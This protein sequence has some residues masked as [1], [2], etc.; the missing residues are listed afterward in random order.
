MIR[1]ALKFGASL[2]AEYANRVAGVAPGEIAFFNSLRDSF[3]ALSARFRIDVIHGSKHQVLFSGSPPPW[4][5][6]QAR[7]E[8]ADLMV[9]SFRPVDK[10][11]RLSFIQVKLER[12][13]HSVLPKPVAREFSANLEQWDLL[14]RRPVIQG[15]GRFSLEPDVLARARLP[16]VGSFVFL[17]PPGGVTDLYYA[18]ADRLTVSGS[19]TQRY[20]KIRAPWDIGFRIYRGLPE[21]ISMIGCNCFGASMYLH[22]IGTPVEDDITRTQSEREFRRRQR[23]WLGGVLRSRKDVATSGNVIRRLLEQLGD[24]EGATEKMDGVPKTIIVVETGGRE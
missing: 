3:L 14:A 13:V 1:A 16:S 21:A 5:R 2:S 15:A 20:A 10:S 11:I 18:S 9:V 19:P 6:G 17:F 4:G 23:R 24:N 12:G 7:C 22:L 8:L